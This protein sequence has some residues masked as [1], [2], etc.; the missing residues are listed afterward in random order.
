MGD[1]RDRQAI[2]RAAHIQANAQHER[3]R[4]T[5]EQTKEMRLLR[6][7]IEG[8]LARLPVD[9]AVVAAE[10]AGVEA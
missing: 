5:R 2:E 10:V 8:L 1:W 9:E 3:A 4:A 6:Q 7:A